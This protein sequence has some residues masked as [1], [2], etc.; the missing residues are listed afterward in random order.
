MSENNE[1]LARL[2]TS[3]ARAYAAD[4][5]NELL[6]SRP[7]AKQGFG[8]DP[9]S[10]W[11][12]W[13]AARVEELAAAVA[14][15]QPRRFTSQVHWCQ[16][17]LAARGVSVEYFRVALRGLRRVLVKELPEQVQPL[18]ARYLDEALDA[19]DDRPTDVSVQLLAD[20]PHGRLASSYLLALLEGDRRR[21]SRVVLDA[22]NQSESVRDV[23]LHVL[24]PAQEELGRMWLT[25]E[26][27]VAEEHFASHTTKMVMGHLLSRAEIQSPNGKTVLTAA[28][29]GN[30]HDIGLYAVAD[31]FE[32][33]GWRTIQLGADV[34]IRDLVEAVEFFEVDLL[35][36]SASLNVQIETVK[37][38]I[39]AVRG[40]SR[41]NVVKILVGGLAFADADNLPEGLGADGHAADPEEAVRLGGR[42][43]GLS[44]DRH[45]E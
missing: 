7:E 1:F 41:G 44:P 20:T 19:F 15:E 27:N 13:L 31:F 42:L 17:V 37:S 29:A 14:V 26:V 10:S 16:A 4:A 43:V 40:G 36:L 5:S 24:L 32:M 30:R 18:A 35:A 21:A 38:T 12:F 2:L 39:Q 34:P 3:G 45:V 11:Q 25:G 33:A 6:E 8:A 23:Y 9:F 22:I 28:V